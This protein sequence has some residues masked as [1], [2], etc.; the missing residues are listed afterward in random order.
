MKQVSKFSAFLAALAFATI[1]QWITLPA[2]IAQTVQQVAVLVNDE[3]ISTFDIQQRAKLIQVSTRRSLND[4][5][6]E[7]ATE[8]LIDEMLKM[9]ASRA[10][11]IAIPDDQ[12]VNALSQM[13]R[14]SNMNLEQFS[15]AL[16]QMGLSVRTLRSR[17]VS[18][19]AWR[20]VVTRRFRGTVRVSEQQV[21]SAIS[22]APT[23]QTAT[24]VEYELKQI[25]FLVRPGASDATVQAR[26]NEAK[27]VRTNLS[28]CGTARSH[29]A[30]IRD[31]VIQDL[32][33]KTSTELPAEINTA[34]STLQI[35]QTTEPHR[36][37]RGIELLIICNREEITD[38]EA[39]RQE[40]QNQ[41]MN[42]EFS[43]V[44]RRHLRDLR[45][46]AVIERR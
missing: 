35:G 41:L 42:E 46:D 36:T 28:S 43:V 45:Q 31:V 6:R 40:V 17:V 26:V 11:N 16:G 4:A 8:Q 7:E 25:L 37:N 3:P 19:L 32:G 39:A 22:D 24:R 38:T 15:R 27:T 20:E 1:A 30:G 18:E 13:A 44:A 14:N 9:Q 2:A 10:L 21:E 23:L 12:I 33:R 29:I 5:L 34:L